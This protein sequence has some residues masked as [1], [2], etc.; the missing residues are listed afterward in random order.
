MVCFTASVIV[1]SERSMSS[2]C[3]IDTSAPR[4]ATP[5]IMTTAASFGS[6]APIIAAIDAPS[7]CPITTMRCGSIPLRVRSQ[8][9]CARVSS[10]SEVV[11]AFS[12]VSRPVDPPMPRSSTRSTAIPFDA[13]RSAIWRKGAYCSSPG[14]AMR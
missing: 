11:V 6:L 4:F 7:L 1:G 9:I 10:A 13:S 2:C 8:A 14:N 12:R 3:S 5:A